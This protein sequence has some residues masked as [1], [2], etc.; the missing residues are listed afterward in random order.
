VAAKI[1][2]PKIKGKSGNVLN[3]DRAV[4]PEPM[5]ERKITSHTAPL[6]REQAEKLRGILNHAGFTFE[7]RPYTLFYAK[8]DKLSVSVYEKGPKVLIQGGDTAEF[9]RFTLEPEILGEATFDYEAEL[10][11]ARFEPHFGIDESGKGD[12]FGPLVIAGAY[13]DGPLAEELKNAGIADSKRITSDAR[14]RQL[15]ATIRKSGVPHTIISIHPQKYNELTGKFGNVNRMLAWGHAT[16]IERLCE[17]RPDCP[18][19]LSDKFAHVRVLESAL[20]EKGRRILLDQQTKAESDYAVAAASILAREAF[21]DWMDREGEVLGLGGS[22]PRGASEKVK[23]V[24]AGLVRSHGRDV[25][26][27]LAKTHFKTA[28]EVLE[29]AAGP[30]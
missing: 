17:L 11:P 16:A 26:Q 15:S 30:A 21:I 4:M 2:L 6:S 20:K 7:P 5:K 28:A 3:N 23:S 14:I 13:V 24:A 9:V 25:L 1:R 27:R 12:F 22:L 19:A 10:H 8:K 18:R 29:I